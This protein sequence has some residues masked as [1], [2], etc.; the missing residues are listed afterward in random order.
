MLLGLAVVIARDSFGLPSPFLRMRLLNM[1]HLRRLALVSAVSAL[2][3]ACTRA[4]PPAAGGS[5]RDEILATMSQSGKEWT[6]GDLTASMGDYLDSSRTTYVTKQ[7]VLRGRDAIRA[8]YAARF[9]P[10]V[11][12]DSLW[13]QNVEVDSLAPGVANVIAFYVLS[14]GDSV[15][16]RG[17]TTVVMLRTASGW[18][19]VHDHSS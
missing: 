1:H 7:E 4:A 19:I 15:I 14:R 18:K 16:A 2:P 5:M 9:A 11:R 6:H 17:P 3:I 12:Q 10:G 8:H 13:F